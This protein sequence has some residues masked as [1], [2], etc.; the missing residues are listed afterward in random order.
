MRSGGTAEDARNDRAHDA[1]VRDDGDGPARDSVSRRLATTAAAR[2]RRSSYP[3][4]PGKRTDGRLRHPAARTAPAATRRSRRRS[5]PSSSPKSSSRRSSRTSTRARVC[6]ERPRRVDGP[7]RG[8]GDDGGELDAGESSGR[9]PPP[10]V[11]RPTTARGRASRSSGRARRRREPRGEEQQPHVTTTSAASERRRLAELGGGPE[12]VAGDAAEPV[13][14]VEPEG[15]RDDGRGAETGEARPPATKREG[16]SRR[17]TPAIIPDV[18][19]P[20]ARAPVPRPGGRTGESARAGASPPGRRAGCEADDRSLP[21]GLAS[22]PS[23][24][25]SIEADE[26]ERDRAEGADRVV[27]HDLERP[28]AVV[29]PSA[30]AVSA[31]A[32]RCSAPVSSAAMPTAS[33]PADEGRQRARQ[34]IAGQPRR[35]PE[36]APPTS[37]KSGR[38]AARRPARRAR[39]AATD[40]IRVRNATGREPPCEHVDQRPVSV[41]PASAKVAISTQDARAAARSGQRE[42]GAGCPRRAAGRGRAAARARAARARARAPARASRCEATSVADR[43]G[44]EARRDERGRRPR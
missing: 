3:S 40:G 41:T 16:Q 28:L 32:S 38:A 42:R 23:A 20:R 8:A 13:A 11:R 12:G 6:G 37:G 15:D 9:A 34:Q 19:G 17:A 22:A 14:V 43:G 5:R 1:A 27:A 31:S 10:A 26:H 4:P 39:D 44:R 18:R 29:P 33:A 25:A 24:A 2:R 21:D 7:A 36:T 35:Q 30:S